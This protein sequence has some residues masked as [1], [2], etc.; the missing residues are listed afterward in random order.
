MKLALLLRYRLCKRLG[1]LFRSL[2]KW[3]WEAHA[4]AHSKYIRKYKKQPR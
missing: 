1:L 4:K 2:D 3:F